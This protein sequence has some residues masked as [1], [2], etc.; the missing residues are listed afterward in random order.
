MVSDEVELGRIKAHRLFSKITYTGTKKLKVAIYGSNRYLLSIYYVPNTVSGT[1]D[2][3]DFS[4]DNNPKIF[5]EVQI[6]RGKV[7]LKI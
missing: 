4:K 1:G 6:F 2:T 7:V 3:A 5:V